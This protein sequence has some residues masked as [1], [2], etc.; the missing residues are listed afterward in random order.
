M[1]HSVHS[2]SNLFAQ[3]GQ[4]SDAQAVA[5]FIE[6]HRPLPGGVLLHEATFWSATQAGFLFEAIADDAD[7]SE[8]ADHLNAELH[9]PG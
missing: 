8:V 1:E 6:S 2:M 5:A 3:L 7:W 9:A 4:A